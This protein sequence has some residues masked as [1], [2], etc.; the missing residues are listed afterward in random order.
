MTCA[1]IFPFP[2]NRWNH[3]WRK[4]QGKRRTLEWIITQGKILEFVPFGSILPFE[5]EGFLSRPSVLSLASSRGIPPS[6]WIQ[7]GVSGL[8]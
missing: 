5:D 2:L 1:M 6:R 7:T 3:C 4:L 8:R